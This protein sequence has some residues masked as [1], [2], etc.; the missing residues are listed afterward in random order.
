MRSKDEVL[1]CFEQYEAQAAA[2]FQMKI[3]RLRC[4]NGGEY[5][6]RRFK[7]FCRSKG[8]QIEFTVPYTPEQNG[9]SERMNRTLVEKA[10]TMLLDSGLDKRFCGQAVQT[11][12]YLLNRSPTSAVVYKQTPFELWEEN[13]CLRPKRTPEEDGLQVV[14]RI[15]GRLHGERLPGLGSGQQTNHCCS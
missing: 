13:V 7:Q 8:I 3:S 14:A 5:T 4:D 9:T 6:G 11:A 10:K 12:A 2:K 15:S 1:G